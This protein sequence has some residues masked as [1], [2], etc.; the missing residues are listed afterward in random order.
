[1]PGWNLKIQHHDQFEE[2]EREQMT[3]LSVLWLEEKELELLK[4]SK[5]E[6]NSIAYHDENMCCSVQSTLYPSL[7][8][9]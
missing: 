4:E 6:N 2:R 5:N 7:N 8:C 1:M 3:K 9:D